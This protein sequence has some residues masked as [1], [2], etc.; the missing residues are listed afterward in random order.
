MPA[1]FPARWNLCH[2]GRQFSAAVLEPTTGGGADEGLLRVRRLVDVPKG[3]N[4]GQEGECLLGELTDKGRESTLA[5][6][7]RLRRLYVD[8]CV[9]SS[10][11]ARG[12]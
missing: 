9:P 10:P 6:G 4:G 5:L 12:G 11:L 7:E 8:E 3:V 1:H 2:V